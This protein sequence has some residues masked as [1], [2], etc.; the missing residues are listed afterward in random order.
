MVA[1]LLHPGATAIHAKQLFLAPILAALGPLIALHVWYGLP[2]LVV[3]VGLYSA[4]Y[5]CVKGWAQ[6]CAFVALG[7]VWLHYGLVFLSYN[8]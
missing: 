1:V 2:M 4:T 6:F 7:A 8:G 3:M 5:F